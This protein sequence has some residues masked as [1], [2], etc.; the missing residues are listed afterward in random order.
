[1]EELLKK[2]AY[3]DLGFTTREDAAEFLL[4]R[5]MSYIKEFT[6]PCLLDLGCGTGA[7]AI[8]A[9][10]ARS[11]IWAIALDISPANVRS[12][13]DKA[14][15][16]GFSNRMTAVCEDYMDWKGESVD[17]IVSDGVL[18]LVGGTNATL[19]TRLS[20][21][22]RLG[23]IM[24]AT[25]PILSFRNTLMVIL[26]RLWS[27]MPAAVDELVPLACDTTLSQLSS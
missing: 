20:S 12:A 4:E 1:M 18:H 6:N 8:A 27:R 25:M 2:S 19:A 3:A 13:R 26:R 7:L 23:E 9:M 15:A 10:R 21:D 11:D 16:A 5:A 14:A 17:L 22:L 24:L